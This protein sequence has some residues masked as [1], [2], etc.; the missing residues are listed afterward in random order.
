MREFPEKR[1]TFFCTHTN[2][3]CAGIWGHGTIQVRRHN[4]TNSMMDDAIDKWSGHND[5][6]FLFVN[7][8]Y[9]VGAWSVASIQ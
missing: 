3:V 9:A 5:A 6:R 4:I 8:K 1:Q 2:P 7:G